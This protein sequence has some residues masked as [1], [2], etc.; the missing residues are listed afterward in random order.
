MPTEDEKKEL[1][2]QARE[3]QANQEELNSQLKAEQDRQAELD[4]QAKNAVES[5]HEAEE[6]EMQSKSPRPTFVPTGEG[7]DKVLEAYRKA[8]HQ[9]TYSD[10]GEAVLS[11]NTPEESRQFF[12]N[13]AQEGHRFLA[14]QVTM[15]SQNKITP[16]GNYKYSCGDK[17]LYSGTRDEIISQLKDSIQNSQGVERKLAQNG[18]SHFK[19]ITMPSA[20]AYREQMQEHRSTK[21]ANN[22]PPSLNSSTEA[23]TPSSTTPNPFSTVPKLPKG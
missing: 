14:V 21:S 13:L 7:L 6:I 5:K 12:G 11:F 16:T 3:K 15:D 17:K 18:L 9:L 10:K 23:S 20:V 2:K 1:E 19:Q 4:L 8:G 22:I